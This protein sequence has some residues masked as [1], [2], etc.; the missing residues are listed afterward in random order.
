[1]A[2]SVCRVELIDVVMRIFGGRGGGASED[3]K[4]DGNLAA[5]AAGARERFVEVVL[6]VGESARG[7]E[8]ADLSCDLEGKGSCV[9]SSRSDGSKSSSAG[10]SSSSPLSSSIESASSSS[11]SAFGSE[12]SCSSPSSGSSCSSASFLLFNR[13]TS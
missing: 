3:G 5:S 12:A 2:A 11:S 8:D 10:S 7:L 4:R 6:R 13:S 9:L 1:M